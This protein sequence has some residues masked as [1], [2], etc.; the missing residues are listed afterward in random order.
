MNYGFLKVA[1]A[2]PTVRVADCEYNCNQIEQL[3]L[4]AESQGVE[5]VVFPELSITGYT[6]Q[7]LFRQSQL[8]SSSEAAVA[9]LVRFSADKDV[10][11]IV[12]A[13]VPAGDLLLNAAIVF[14]KG[15]LLGIV[16]KTYL[17][18]YAEFYEKRWFASSQD[19]RPTPVNYAGEQL[20]VH[21]DPMLFTTAEGVRFG[22]EICEDVWA[23]T[24]PSNHLALAGADLI[25]N[26][27]ASDELIGKHAYL[28]SLLSQ[29]SARTISG[30]VYSGCGFGEST[31]DVVYGGNA[32]IY[33]NGQLLAEGIANCTNRY[34]TPSN[35]T[36]NKYYIR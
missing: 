13:P 32:I 20:I 12:G 33:E 25:F 35:R 1:A 24:P 2:V 5:I 26:L 8:L 19:L 31:Q 21:S 22:I 29:Q 16:P 30:Y 36:T 34:R 4:Q 14:Q 9:R 11:V 23:P 7:D 17:P 28:E 3:I 18:N 15:K 10:I 6:C 27:S